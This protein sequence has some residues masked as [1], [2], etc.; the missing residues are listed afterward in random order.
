MLVALLF[1]NQYDLEYLTASIQQLKLEDTASNKYVIFD[2]KI[3]ILSLSLIL[4]LLCQPKLIV[5]KGFL[6]LILFTEQV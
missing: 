4:F 2:N 5:W 6:H 1:S 3:K